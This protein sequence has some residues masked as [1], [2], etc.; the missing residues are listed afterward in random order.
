MNCFGSS[1]GATKVEKKLEQ[2][3]IGKSCF[4]AQETVCLIPDFDV[5][6]VHFFCNAVLGWTMR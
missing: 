5:V 1:I 2:K 3:Q 4:R 6:I